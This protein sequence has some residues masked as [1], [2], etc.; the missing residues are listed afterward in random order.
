MP[1]LPE[2]LPM[3]LAMAQRRRDLEQAPAALA[4][5]IELPAEPP[6]PEALPPLELASRTV[7]GE[8][9]GDPASQ[10]AVAAVLL[11]RLAAMRRARPEA[12][13]AD[14]ALAPKQFSAWNPGNPNRAAMLAVPQE[15]PVLSGIRG[16][17]AGMMARRLADPTGG[18]TMYHVAG[19]QPPWDWSKLEPTVTLGAHAFYRK[20]RQK[21]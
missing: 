21:R 20:K 18:A 5:D 15:D 13:L 14:V 16:L 12:A 10:Q 4:P 9:R 3:L 1:E 19:E 11:N 8:A 2:L 17:V 7:Y 6:G